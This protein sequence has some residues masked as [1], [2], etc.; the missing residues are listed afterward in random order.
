LSRVQRY[1][2]DD[3]PSRKEEHL[4]RA[5]KDVHRRENQLEAAIES[6]SAR[7]IERYKRK[8]EQAQERLRSVSGEEK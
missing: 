7:M 4:S 1:C 3:E 6:G 8:L 5:L 2:R